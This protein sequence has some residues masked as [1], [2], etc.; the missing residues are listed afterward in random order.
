MK[1]RPLLL[2]DAAR[3]KIRRG[4]DALAEAIG[5]FRTDEGAA[6]PSGARRA[7]VAAPA[8]PRAK[9]RTAS[10]DGGFDFDLGEGSD[11]LDARFKRRDAA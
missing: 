4:A 5:F 3:D 11:D 7:S 1:A 8:A 2:H 6:A 9:V 10:M